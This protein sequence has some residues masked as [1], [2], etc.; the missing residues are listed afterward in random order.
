MC[1]RTAHSAQRTAH[2]AQWWNLNLIKSNDDLRLT[3]YEW[4]ILNLIKIN[5]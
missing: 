3:I 2:S 4:W 1:Q 5:S